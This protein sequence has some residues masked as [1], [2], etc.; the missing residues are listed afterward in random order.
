MTE[1]LSYWLHATMA[2][3]DPAKYCKTDLE[4]W[5]AGRLFE[6]YDFK[7]GK[8]KKEKRRSFE[9]IWEAANGNPEAI[10]YGFNAALKSMV[11]SLAYVK[12]CI[13]GFGTP[14]PTP[15]TP[16][17]AQAA[18]KHSFQR[19][20]PSPRKPRSVKPKVAEPETFDLDLG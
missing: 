10:A 13:K 15:P 8:S 18:K 19:P 6:R 3:G 11:L 16:P 5:I 4:I 12:A 1:D 9:E 2:Q 17:Q 20:T 7:A 14:S